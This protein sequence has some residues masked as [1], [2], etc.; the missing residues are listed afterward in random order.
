MESLPQWLCS[1]GGEE[2]EGIVEVLYGKR[3]SRYWTHL[4]NM[5][6]IGMLN[7]ILIDRQKEGTRGSSGELL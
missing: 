4:L 6:M 5:P 7:E 1:G 2:K 3:S